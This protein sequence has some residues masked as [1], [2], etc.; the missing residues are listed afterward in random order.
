MADERITE[1]DD[2]VTRER[3]VETSDPDRTV[4]VE[5]RGGGGAMIVGIVLLIAVRLSVVPGQ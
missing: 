4:A 2:G 1:R 3:V 5:R